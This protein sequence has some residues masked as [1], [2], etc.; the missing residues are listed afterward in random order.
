MKRVVNTVTGCEN[1]QTKLK[2]SHLENRPIHLENSP[3]KSPNKVLRNNNPSS[4]TKTVNRCQPEKVEIPNSDSGEINIDIS[5]FNSSLKSIQKTIHSLEIHVSELISSSTLI[6]DMNSR[7]KS[8]E[9]KI[10]NHSDIENRLKEIEVT[11]KSASSQELLTSVDSKLKEIE[12][13]SNRTQQCLS[14]FENRLKEIEIQS[15]NRSQNVEDRIKYLE[16]K[17]SLY[18]SANKDFI[19]YLKQ[20]TQILNVKTIYRYLK[21]QIHVI[22]FLHKKTQTLCMEIGYQLI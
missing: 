14:S 9:N 21:S 5:K 11:C 12:I 2:T 6:H 10:I 15:S 4:K 22:P 3:A 19:D 17:A 18:S 20:E 8:V 13:S 1:E 16:N 7:L